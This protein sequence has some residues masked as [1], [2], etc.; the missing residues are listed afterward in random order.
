MS[1]TPIT[2]AE[3]MA[4]VTV[5]V[6][7]DATV[8]AAGAVLIAQHLAGVPVVDGTH[9][10][11]VVS[12]QQ[13]LHQ[14]PQRR[15]SEV[16][17]GLRTCATPDLALVQARAL[18]VRQS[19]EVLP[20]VAEGRL[21][22][23]ASLVAI[24][25]ATGQETDA[26][27]GLPWATALRAWAT[28]ELVQGREI[29]VLFIDL[30]D[31]GAVNK[32]LGHVEGDKILRTVAALLSGA[33]DPALDLLCRYGGDEFAIATRREDADVRALA[34]RVQQ[35]AVVRAALGDAPGRVT[36]SVGVAGGRRV[37]PRVGAHIAANVDDLLSLASRSSTA[38]KESKRKGAQRAAGASPARRATAGPAEAR[39]RLIGVVA[40]NNP[41]QGAVS[42]RLRLGSIEGTGSASAAGRRVGSIVL[43][44]EAT[45][46][47]LAHTIG[48]AFAFAVDNVTETPIAG[49][50]QVV[51]ILT[52]RT[53]PTCARQ[54]VGAARATDASVAAVKAVLDALNRVLAKPLA[55]ILAAG[56]TPKDPD[57]GT[58]ARLVS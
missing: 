36:V 29:A 18:A 37:Q 30:D 54:L 4:L 8:A 33:V 10:I 16:M 17:T 15:V 20:V 32:H 52:D 56:A 39:L 41:D 11:G 44:A 2:V 53:D 25:K 57:P 21:V 51:A 55:E 12:P 45:V 31:F 9:V 48:D 13:L 40:S 23:Q 26:L 42:V 50:T 1:D 43:A 24:L 5:S 35:Q 49:G 47:A 6:P 38:V 14:A 3:V 7:P 27:T 34:A 22:G 58:G 19:V 28:K 46:A